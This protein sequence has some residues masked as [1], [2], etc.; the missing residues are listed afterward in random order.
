VTQAQIVLGGG[1]GGA[2]IGETQAQVRQRLGA[3]H[4][5]Y[6][7]SGTGASCRWQEANYLQST[8]VPSP[9]AQLL[10]SRSGR[11]VDILTGRGNQRTHA[12]IKVGSTQAEVRRAYPTAA[13][14]A[15]ECVLAA[16]RAHSA[17]VTTFFLTGHTVAAIEVA[18]ADT[19]TL[20]LSPSSVKASGGP[21]SAQSTTTATI[22]LTDSAGDPEIGAV[23]QLIVTASAGN[24]IGSITPLGGVDTGR[25]TVQVIA[26]SHKGPVTIT[27]T[28]HWGPSALR[29]VL[30]IS[31]STV[32]R[33]L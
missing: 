2:S 14:A 7:W 5:L 1:I 4:Q 33:Q 9:V 27:A 32:L 24:R 22:T 28:F 3:P 21:P 16:K 8:K 12:G 10:F 29:R 6:C 25:Y 19:V 30:G 20:T 15:Q 26:T 18:S 11:V 17:V 13:C 31:A 23:P